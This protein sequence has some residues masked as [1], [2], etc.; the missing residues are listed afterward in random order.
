MHTSPASPPH[1][2]ATPL[3]VATWSAVILLALAGQVAWNVEN[4]W[5][6][7]F[8][9]DAITP[10]PAPVAWMVA[11]S[12]V[13]ATLTTFGM[14][15]LSD[16]L[17]RRKPFLIYG[18]ILW[19]ITTALFPSAALIRPLGL[20][21]LAVIVLDAL[22]TFF[23]STA[24]D[25]AFNAWLADVTDTSNRAKVMGAIAI[26]PL[27]VTG[28][29]AVI[30]GLV[31]DS[32]GYFVFFY[33]LGGFVL[34]TGL[35]CAP[36]VRE[37]PSLT[38]ARGAASYG[39]QLLAIFRP[40]TVR[41]NRSLYL[42]F[43]SIML[44]GIA[45]QISLPYLFIYLE[46]YIGIS[47]TTIGV[48]TLALTLVAGGLAIGFSQFIDRWDRRRT[49]IAIVLFYP[50][51]VFIFSMLR[52]VTAFYLFGALYVA[53]MLLSGVINGAWSM[54][55]YPQESRGQFQGM[56]MIFQVLLP[57]VIGPQIGAAIIARTGIPTMLNGAAGFIP[58]PYLWWGTALFGL[59][60]VVPLV[61]IREGK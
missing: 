24:N 22:M 11:A 39:Q 27:L 58:T 6:N 56:R 47:K 34:L 1:P 26:M 17:G 29:T 25:A 53:P 35:L 33:A 45:D 32:L 49:A 48:V 12:A 5:F 13:T 37:S 7:T 55:L 9:F 44:V 54:D 20:A 30:A 23:G 19:G 59:L 28:L 41:Q 16:R 14:G 52:S 60:G 31:I 50:V 10:D 8:V 38:P 18:Y 21:I 42:L 2:R 61:L 43:S 51:G 4:S 40:G 46:N 36:L 15:T 57:M 3:P